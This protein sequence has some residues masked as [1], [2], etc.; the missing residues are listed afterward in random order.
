M[1]ALDEWRKAEG[2]RNRP[3][4]P[5]P[6]KPAPEVPLGTIYVRGQ[7]REARPGS[8]RRCYH[9][10]FPSSDW[11]ILWSDWRPLTTDVGESTLKGWPGFTRDDLKTEY[12]WEENQ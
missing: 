6:E 4:K 12:K 10:C 1:S 9:G 7:H 3:E 5:A 11:E 2:R 8:Q